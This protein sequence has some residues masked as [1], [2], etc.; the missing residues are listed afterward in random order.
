MNQ[1]TPL[2]PSDPHTGFDLVI[3]NG[4][5]I[6]PESGLDARK[7]IGINDGSIKLVTSKDIT[8]SETINAEGM[9]VAP[10]FIDIHQ[11]GQDNENYAYKINDGVTTALELELGT[12]DVDTWYREREG[13]SLINHG[14]SIGHIPARMKLMKDPGV[15]GPVADA[16]YRE[17]SESEIT[18]L[19]KE[20]EQGLNRG[21]LAVGFGIMYTP[22]A[23]KW[24]ILEMFRV[25]SEYRA[26]CIVH[27]RYAGLKEPNSAIS[28][29]EEVISASAITGAPLH[30]VHI[31]SMGFRRTPQMLRMIK[32][33]RSHGLDI[34]VECYPYSATQTYIE[35]AIYDEGWQ[36]TL[37]ITYGDLQWA[38]TGER[39]T[40]ETFKRYRTTSG[41][42]IAHSIPEEVVK[43]AIAEPTVIIASDGDIKSGKGHP[44]G[45]SS[46]SRLLGRYVRDEGILSLTEALKK[47]T[48]M[49]AKRLE[50][51]APG[52]R[53]K[54]RIC[55]DA[56]ADITIFD[57]AT[58][59]DRATYDNPTIRPAGIHF[60]LVNGKITIRNGS[61]ENGIYPGMAVRGPFR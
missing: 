50:E 28:A 13:K 49:P 23:S 9:V 44:R 56:D 7:N 51:I 3:L 8:G 43:S 18:V 31:T 4:R 32:E 5:V 1:S 38:A 26:P 22:A 10:G 29:L 6:D 55:K 45:T 12:A 27:M 17:A 20:I 34:S 2:I 54:G 14:V 30:I 42:V 11:H 58:I 24:E 57:P 39:L 41:L 25:A 36:E 40:S 53:K 15:F 46:F 60:V 61:L 37:G 33:A 52:M 35:T 59:A 47:I 21:A 16:A 19:K 48:I